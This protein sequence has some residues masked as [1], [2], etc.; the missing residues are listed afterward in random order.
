M[1]CGLSECAFVPFGGE[2]LHWQTQ[3]PQLTTLKKHNGHNWLP[4][5]KTNKRGVK[6]S[7]TAQAR[8][9][10]HSMA[11]ITGK[12]TNAHTNT[13]THLTQHGANNR[14]G[15][16]RTHKHT[17]TSQHGANNRQGHQRTHKHTQHL[18]KTAIA[19]HTGTHTH[20]IA[21]RYRHTHTPA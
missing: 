11:L 16:Q 7:D 12:A 4:W 1:A 14:Q 17:R 10:P 6:E 8:H 5:Q 21:C 15:H 9:A 2:I 18:T 20:N 13:H 19:L 3:W